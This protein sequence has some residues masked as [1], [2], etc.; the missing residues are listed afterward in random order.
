MTDSGAAQLPTPEELVHNVLGTADVVQL[1]HL[2]RRLVR[3]SS[4][5]FRIVHEVALESTTSG[6]GDRIGTFRAHV[7]HALGAPGM[8]EGTDVYMVAQELSDALEWAHQL[9][10]QDAGALEPELRRVLELLRL[11]ILHADDPGGELE[12]VADQAVGLFRLATRYSCVSRESRQELARWIV[13]FS[14]RPTTGS[15]AIPLRDFSGAL[16][17]EGKKACDALLDQWEQTVG[18]GASDVAA[19]LDKALAEADEQLDLDRETYESFGYDPYDSAWRP[20]GWSVEPT[21]ARLR[22]MRTEL[23]QA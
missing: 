3:E 7:D 4:E 9:L 11:R 10:P 19:K 15:P 20:T 6:V 14:S 8:L 21:S 18:R 22:R 12:G 13:E 1:Q 2:I 5:A 17:A 23:R 16:G